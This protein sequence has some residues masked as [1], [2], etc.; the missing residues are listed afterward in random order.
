M[1]ENWAAQGVEVHVLSSSRRNYPKT[2]RINGVWVHR[3]GFDSLKEVLYYW[4]GSTGGRG[5]IG[6]GVRRPG[7]WA[8]FWGWVYQAVWKNLYFPDDACLWY[9]PARNKA[10]ELL[11]THSFDQ[12]ITVSLPFTGHM[13]GLAVRKKYPELPWLADIGDPFTIQARPLNNAVFYGRWSRGFEKRV[14]ETAEVVTITHQTVLAAF[15]RKFGSAA[16][17]MQ[18]IP[19]LLHPPMASRP[20]SGWWQR[21][22]SDAT[23]IHLGYFGAFYA[24]VRTPDAFL[25]LLD[26]T[27]A[28]RPDLARRFQIHFFGEIFPEFWARLSRY[29]NILLHGLRPRAEVRVFMRRM[30]MLLHIGNSTEYQFPSK[31][32]E[33]F[34]SGKP[35]VHLSYVDDDPFTG[36]WGKE[37][38]L[39]VLR[40]KNGRVRNEDVEQWLDLLET[41]PFP[42]GTADRKEQLLPYLLASIARRYESLM[43]KE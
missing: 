8:R 4:M 7:H 21:M 18:V 10:F 25:D 16:N 9:F 32:V 15:Q 34:A 36:L 33:Y 39:L 26:T 27:I 40:V 41:E 14:L 37:T 28:R 11:D 31:A 24:P 3:T 13:V 38:G 17:R 42:R 20:D 1:A 35:V 22:T 29:P 2:S 19:P 43:W 5:R 6:A 30:D 12:I 23:A